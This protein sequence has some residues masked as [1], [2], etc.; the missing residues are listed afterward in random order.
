MLM[1]Q[2]RQAELAN[3][4]GGGGGGGGSNS[5]SSLFRGSQQLSPPAI[6]PIL[7]S[8]STSTSTAAGQLPVVSLTSIQAEQIKSQDPVSVSKPTTM[9]QKIQQQQPPSK[10]SGGT[11]GWA[12]W[13]SNNG[14]GNASSSFSNNSFPTPANSASSVASKTTLNSNSVNLSDSGKSGSNVS[15]GFWN[16]LSESGSKSSSKQASSTHVNNGHKIA[17]STSQKK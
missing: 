5:W 2:M 9:S 14:S 1:E 6:G 12:A 8:N 15:G 11:T 3:Q 10:T 4:N 16:E 17:N 13:G 7:S